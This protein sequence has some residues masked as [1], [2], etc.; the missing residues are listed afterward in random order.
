MNDRLSRKDVA[1]VLPSDMIRW[2]VFYYPE[3][4]STQNKAAELFR[5][6]GR[7]GIFVV[8]DYQSGGRGREERK[9]I[10]PP[11]KA[12]LFSFVLH[13]GHV[14][15]HLPL[16]TITTVLGVCR[17]IRSRL[18]LKP[19]VKWPNDVLLDGKKVCGILTEVV[20]SGKGDEAVVVGIG[21]NVNQASPDFPG[22]LAH[23]ATSLSIEKREG[24][25]R[26]SLLKQIMSSFDNHYFLYQ[27]GEH[28]EI[29]RRWKSYSSILG[30]HV[31]VRTG[32]QE[33]KGTVVDLE[34]S[35]AIVLRLDTGQTKSFFGSDC[36]FI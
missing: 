7:Y 19:E 23:T 6:Q 2:N 35:G 31:C 10:A 18:D 20:T 21:L 36:R 1:E 17:A 12:L 9:W 29:V 22:E 26:L 28:H 14:P 24:I 25:D 34:N 33:I 13:A 32:D 3:L 27:R 8:T 15:S 11:G 30:R 16:L 4:D 5:S